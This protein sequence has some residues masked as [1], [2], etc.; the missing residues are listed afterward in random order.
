VALIHFN[1]ATFSR[2]GDPGYSADNWDKKA[3]YAAGKT[4]DPATFNPTKLDTDQWAK[5]MIDLGAKHAV[6]TAKHGC[7]H[8]LWPTKVLLPSGKEYTYCVGKEKSA[9]KTDVLAQFSN[10]MSKAGIGHGFYYS[11]TN[12]FYLDVHSHFVQNHT[13]LPGQE[14]VTQAQF[15]KIALGHVTEL[16]SNYG[17]LAEIWFDG[18]YTGDM[19]VAIETLLNSTQADAVAFGGNGVSKNPVCWVGTESGNPG[20]EIWSTGGN[21]KGDPNSM[22]FCPKGCDTTLQNGDVWFYEKSSS[23][24]TLAQLITVYHASI[25][26]NG[27]IELDFAIDRDGLVEESQASRYKEFGNWIKNCYGSPVGSTHGN[28][29]TVTLELITPTEI[30]RVM[31]QEDLTQGQRIRQFTVQVMNAAKNWQVF[32]SAHSVGNKRI[33]LGKKVVTNKLQLV[34]QNS[35]GNPIVINFSTFKPCPSA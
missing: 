14:K 24:R 1:M 12:N 22:L 23:I 6:L 2:N 5:V 21:G 9:I 25:G 32:G 18:G 8:L 10:S 3:S 35:V 26:M 16:W 17:N 13:L 15:E 34:I 33:M 19:K 28:G 31:I 7:G 20:G 11:L 27:V 4:N 30:D 29:T